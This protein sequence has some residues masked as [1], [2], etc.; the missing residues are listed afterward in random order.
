LNFGGLMPEPIAVP[1]LFLSEPIVLPGMVVP[2]E[3]DDAARTAVDAA[4]ASDSGK[5]LIAPRQDD[6]LAQEQNG[7]CNWFR[8]QTSKVQ[9]DALNLGGVGFVPGMPGAELRRE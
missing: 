1:I 9:S 8:H 5:L 6:R 2:V 3:L 7:H 4:Q